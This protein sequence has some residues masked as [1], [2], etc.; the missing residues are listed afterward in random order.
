[1]TYYM[2]EYHQYRAIVLSLLSLNLTVSISFNVFYQ[3]FTK[4]LNTTWKN[5]TTCPIASTLPEYILVSAQSQCPPKF[6]G[7][8]SIFIFMISKDEFM[9]RLQELFS[10]QIQFSDNCYEQLPLIKHPYIVNS[11]ES[12][13]GLGQGCF[14]SHDKYCRAV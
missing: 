14:S 11:H 9:R 4:Q 1:M 10:A 7:A 13:R 8:Q 2:E 12:I 6:H 3:S 5:A